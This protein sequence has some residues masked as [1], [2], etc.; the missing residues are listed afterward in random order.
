MKTNRY[1]TVV[2][3]LDIESILREF[4]ASIITKGVGCLIVINKNNLMPRWSDG[5]M[6][7][8][9]QATGPLAKKT[10]SEQHK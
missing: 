4:Q 5:E 6:I 8:F 10:P 1:A 2:Q 9:Q 7:L 3:Q